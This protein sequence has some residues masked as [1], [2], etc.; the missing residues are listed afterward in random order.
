MW[1]S[2]QFSTDGI[3]LALNKFQ[4]LDF[5]I[6]FSICAYNLEMI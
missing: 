4:I 2:V 3:M 1:S 6:G 5:Q